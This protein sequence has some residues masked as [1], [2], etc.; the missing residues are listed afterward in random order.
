M[1]VSIREKAE[2]LKIAFAI[3]FPMGNSVCGVA[4]S[5]KQKFTPGFPLWENHVCVFWVYFTDCWRRDVCASN[6]SCL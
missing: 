6:Q 5:R 3:F 1:T 2:I 4:S